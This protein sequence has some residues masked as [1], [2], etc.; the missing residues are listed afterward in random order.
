MRTARGLRRVSIGFLLV[1]LSAALV[2]PAQETPGRARDSGEGSEGVVLAV[3]SWFSLLLGGDGLSP[4]ATRL[5]GREP[6]RSDLSSPA[7]SN[8]KQHVDNPGQTPMYP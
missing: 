6:G 2:A 1:G 5:E 4:L 7:A 3:Q 8:L